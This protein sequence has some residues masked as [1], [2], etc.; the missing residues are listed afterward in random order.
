MNEMRKCIFDEA[1][2]NIQKSQ[3]RQ[4][5][6]YDK[7]VNPKNSIAIG[8]KVLLRNHKRDDRKGGKLVKPWIGPYTVTNISNTNNC[9]LKN[10]KNVILK[11]KYNL[12]S[13]SLYKEKTLSNGSIQIEEVNKLSNDNDIKIEPVIKDVESSKS[14]INTQH[15]SCVNVLDKEIAKCATFDMRKLIAE[16]FEIVWKHNVAV[17]NINLTLCPQGLHR[18][19]G[20][21]NCF[22]RAVSFIITGSED[23][24]KQIRDKV[25]NHMCNQIHDEMTGYLSMPIQ[26]HICKTRMLE[27]ATWAT[28]A[29]IIGCAS[30]MEVDIQV[31]SK[32]G[33]K[34][35]WMIYPCSLRLN[36]LSDYSIFLDNSTGFHFDVVINS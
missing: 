22:F 28:D 7:R 13:L 26:T 15:E 17:G 11:K 36:K 34:T 19:K 21:G 27:D 3:V 32:Y 20:D 1:Y 12:T 29:E 35:K 9:S 2:K 23:E 18:I 31:Y 6:D 25:V 33:E 16:K 4:K 30:F 5:R 10:E 24:H 14:Y 8:T